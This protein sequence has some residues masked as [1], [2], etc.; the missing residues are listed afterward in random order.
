MKLPFSYRRREHSFQVIFLGS[1]LGHVLVLGGAGLFFS[2]PQYAV[3]EAPTSME[4]VILKEKNLKSSILSPPL[5]RPEESVQK[6]AQP[7]Q[8]KK[9]QQPVLVPT[10][11]GAR[12]E[13]M[14]EYLR[15]PAP[16]YPEQAR[17]R[18]WQ[19]TVVLK[20]L[21]AQDGRSARLRVEKSSGYPIL[22]T[23]ALRAVRTWQFLPARAGR[24]TFSS[25]IKVPVRFVLVDEAES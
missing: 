9:V 2:P 15:N 22:D 8:A 17:E 10:L 13:A 1:F 7:P 20:V 3:R 19:G 4:V 18:N 24:F 12:H 11:R 6:K 21:V 5:V 23:A 16:V 25:W 14:P